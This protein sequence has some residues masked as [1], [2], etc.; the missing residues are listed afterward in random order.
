MKTLNPT[1]KQPAHIDVGIST[2]SLACPDPWWIAIYIANA[3]NVTENSRNKPRKKLCTARLPVRE[4]AFQRDSN[5]E[6]HEK[7]EKQMP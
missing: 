1:L 2:S 7:Q 4:A 5:H 3:K 6:C